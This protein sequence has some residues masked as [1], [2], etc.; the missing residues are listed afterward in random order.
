M[1]LTVCKALLI[2]IFSLLLLRSNIMAN[3]LFKIQ[4]ILIKRVKSELVERSKAMIL[5]VSSFPALLS[6]CLS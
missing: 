5:A 1:L 4:F 6:N 3:Q 2:Y